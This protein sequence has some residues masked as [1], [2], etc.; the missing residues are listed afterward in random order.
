MTTLKQLILF[1]ITLTVIYYAGLAIITAWRATALDYQRI[2]QVVE[3]DRVRNGI[4]ELE[5]KQ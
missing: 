2:G 1:L 4:G 5:G 3:Q